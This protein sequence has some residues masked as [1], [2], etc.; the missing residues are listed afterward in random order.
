M[1]VLDNLLENAGRVSGEGQIVR[2]AVGSVPRGEMPPERLPG[3]AGAGPLALLVVE[4]AGPGVPDSEKS[5]IFEPFYQAAN[6]SRARRGGVGLGLAICR[7]IVSAHG[8]RI[9][10]EDAPQHGSRFIVA[11]PAA[12]P[13]TATVPA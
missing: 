11:L 1:R 3:L 4:D 12:V 8:G 2:I 9:W 13:A 7:E 5:R 10:V 6:G